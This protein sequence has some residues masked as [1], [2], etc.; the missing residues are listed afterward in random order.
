MNKMKN[1]Y[2]DMARMFFQTR[3]MLFPK[4]MMGTFVACFSEQIS[5]AK[6]LC[7]VFRGSCFAG[8][9]A[10]INVAEILKTHIPNTTVKVV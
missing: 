7:A 3:A 6:P 8:I 10:K 5:V 9:S 2:P 4:G 1:E